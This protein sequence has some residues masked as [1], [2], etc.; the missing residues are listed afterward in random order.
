MALI[1][2][3]SS[4]S[5]GAPRTESW[6]RRILAAIFG[7]LPERTLDLIHILLRKAGH[8]AAYAI[9]AWL[10]YRSA[11]GPVAPAT[12]WSRRAAVYALGFSLITAA[13]DELRQLLTE[14]RSGSAWDVALDM[15]GALLAL[16]I[17]RMVAKR[18]ATPAAQA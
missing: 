1:L 2:L 13:F 5:L 7:A 12:I 15:A 14:T 11:R 16:G 3:A 9:L 10:S 17:I 6:L 18:K 4:D 8:L